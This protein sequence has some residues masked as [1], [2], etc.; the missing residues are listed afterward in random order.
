MGD[1]SGYNGYSRAGEGLQAAGGATA[2]AM[3]WVGAGLTAAGLLS[4]LYGNYKGQ[5]VAE[6]NYQEQKAEYERER[7]LLAQQARAEAMQRSL[8]NE[9]SAKGAV[10]GDS[11]RSLARY[12]DYY[13]GVGL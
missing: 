1:F 2:A 3:P 11:D 8:Q 7:E 12:K 5:Q 10:D 13:R 9:Y 4:S 6:R